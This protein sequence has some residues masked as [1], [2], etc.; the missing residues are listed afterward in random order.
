LA[1]SN[2]YIDNLLMTPDGD[3]AIVETKSRTRNHVAAS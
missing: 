2:G 1:T 3:I